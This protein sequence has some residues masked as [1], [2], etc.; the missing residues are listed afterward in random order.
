[1]INV[2]RS[3]TFNNF[4]WGRYMFFDKFDIFRHRASWRAQQRCK[5]DA[6][7]RESWCLMRSTLTYEYREYIVYSL[8][9]P[10]CMRRPSRRT[11]ILSLSLCSVPF[12]SY[13]HDVITI[14]TTITR[15]HFDPQRSIFVFH[16]LFLYFPLLSHSFS[17]SS[18]SLSL[19]RRKN[20]E[21]GRGWYTRMIPP[22]A[23]TWIGVYV[24]K[25]YEKA[26]WREK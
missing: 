14:P 20:C 4:P 17:L 5:I 25:D 13:I 19:C 7:D 23:H 18:L 1:M 8:Y 26:R 24:R 10:L 16:P 2:I 22:A 3:W 21:S 11:S 6:H 12:L 15:S 9:E